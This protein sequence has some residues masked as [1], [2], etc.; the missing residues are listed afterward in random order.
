LGISTLFAIFA[1][2]AE[3]AVSFLG[4]AAGDA[5]S[6][7]VTLWTRAVDSVTPV[8]TTLKLEITT[9][10]AFA[11]G[12]TPLPGACTTDSTKDF[13]CKVEVGGLGPDTVYFYRFVGP[14]SED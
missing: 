3:A 13:I 1:I 8:N 14:A 4:V 6:T 2:S 10:P 9:D 5:S 7:H 11:S 12:I